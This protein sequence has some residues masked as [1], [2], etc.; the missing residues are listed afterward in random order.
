MDCIR[1]QDPIYLFAP[2]YKHIAG[3]EEYAFL[4]VRKLCHPHCKDEKGD[5]LSETVF[6]SIYR[7][8]FDRSRDIQRYGQKLTK[9]LA[10][11]KE[12]K[13][14]HLREEKVKS[15]I[16]EYAAKLAYCSRESESTVNQLPPPLMVGGRGFQPSI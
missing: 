12:C 6:E 3:E 11:I 13:N 7:H 14:E 1:F 2:K 8:S 15:T 10:H 4:G 9:E 5:N 16:E